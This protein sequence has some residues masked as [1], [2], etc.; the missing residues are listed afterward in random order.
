MIFDTQQLQAIEAGAAA[1]ALHEQYGGVEITEVRRQHEGWQRQATRHL[2]TGRTGE[3]VAVYAHRD[4]VHAADTRE[5]ARGELIERWDRDRQ[6][7]A[8]ASRIILTH[9]N[10]EVRELNDAA[11]KRMHA[12]GELGE[13]VRVKTERGDR[14]FATGDRIMFLRNERSL[15]VKNGTL[16]TIERVS[17][18]NMAVRTDDGRSVAFDTKNYR[19]LD[20]GY[21][22][23]IHKAQGMTVDRSHVLAT[24]GMD[25]HGAYVAMSR[26]REGMAFHYGRDDFKNQ[27]QLVRT[28]SRDRLKD[29]AQDYAKADPAQAFAERRGISFGERVK[30]VPEKARGMFD[31]LRLQRPAHDRDMFGGLRLSLGKPER[32]PTP[33]TGRSMFADFRPPAPAVEPEKAARAAHEHEQRRAVQRH[34]RAVAAIAKMKERSVP[35]MPHQRNELDKAREALNRTHADAAKDLETAYARDPALAERTAEGRTGEAV[36][37]MRAEARLRVDPYSR[38]DR[39]VADWQKL[40]QQRHAASRG[41]DR[42]A[43][44]RVSNEMGAMAKSLERDAQMESVLRG[45]KAELGIGRDTG[46][47]LARDLARSVGIGIERGRDLGMSL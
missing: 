4:M 19:D 29:M 34:A 42:E 35:A 23:T 7:D 14:A 41:G 20:H 38:A 21:A 37:A 26:H 13:D 43:V 33:E 16:A 44:K 9:T 32:S 36:A 6:A 46:R 30:A 40:D 25:R 2:A 31:G 39:F 17:E 24:P 45:R 11:R 5:A 15:E 8:D 27:D 28:L 3:A 18:Q 22:A 10:A 1:R 12:G 47:E